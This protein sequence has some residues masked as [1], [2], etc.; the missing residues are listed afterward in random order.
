MSAHAEI[1]WVEASYHAIH[2]VLANP[3]YAGAYVYGKTRTEMTLD[4]S[5]VRRKRIR[6]LPRDHWQVLIKEHHEGFIDWQTYE[7][8]QQRNA[9]RA[10]QSGWCCE[11][12]QRPPAGPR[13]LRA[14][15]PPFAHALSRP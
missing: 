13:Q 4:A 1:R 2:Q 14:L 9:T 10:A 11:G 15:R 6:L 3:V 8:N 5:G 7:A 12:R